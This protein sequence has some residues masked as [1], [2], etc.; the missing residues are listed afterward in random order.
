MKAAVKDGKIQL[1]KEIL[2]YLH[3]KRGD[4]VIFIEQDGKIIVKNANLPQCQIVISKSL[5]VSYM[6]SMN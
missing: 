2:N 5:S 3:L 4:E 6:K 1:T